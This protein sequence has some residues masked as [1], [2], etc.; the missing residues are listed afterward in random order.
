MQRRA[1]IKKT[2]LALSNGLINF[3][4]SDIIHRA[5]P[6]T[7]EKLPVIGMGS[8]RTFNVSS[9]SEIDR[10]IEII[11]QLA[12]SG[13]KLIDTSPMYGRSES[14]IGE[15]NSILQNRSA[16]SWQTKY[17]QPESKME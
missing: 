11:E 12:I 2:S 9:K 14:V 6:S 10:R 8:W 5:I 1:F 3:S 13:N 4:F 17:G 16:F 7:G 15:A